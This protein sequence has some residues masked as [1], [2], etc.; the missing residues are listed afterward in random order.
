MFFVI[1]YLFL[2]VHVDSLII[3]G[4]CFTLFSSSIV[5][6]S[7]LYLPILRFPI[8]QRRFLATMHDYVR[9][10]LFFFPPP[11]RGRVLVR[12]PKPQRQLVGGQPGRPG[13]FVRDL[14]ATP[15][16]PPAPLRDSQITIQTLGARSVSNLPLRSISYVQTQSVIF[17]LF[18]SFHR[19][20]KQ[21]N[22][23]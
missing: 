10:F 13:F 1:V 12:P 22:L 23:T 4:A 2:F 9:V 11:S 7:S 6:C 15:S 5:R 8:C 16:S 18:F 19:I 14:C 3:C 21:L 20:I 17:G